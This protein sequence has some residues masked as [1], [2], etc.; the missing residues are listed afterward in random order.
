MHYRLFIFPFS[1]LT[2]RTKKGQL[3]DAN[4][5]RE[6]IHTNSDD[7]V[8]KKRSSI[9]KFSR[10]TIKSNLEVSDSISA[11]PSFPAKKRV[12]VPQCLPSETPTRTE[13]LE[14]RSDENTKEGFKNISSVPRENS[15][16]NERG[17]AVLSP[18]FWL[19]DDEGLEKLSQHTIGSQHLDIT[20]PDIP[21][22]SDIKDSD[23]DCPSKLSTE[24]SDQPSV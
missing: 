11:K 8:Q 22:F 24:V 21:T 14:I 4:C 17:E 15:A 18:F 3:D 5:G 1:F 6:D 19:R 12:Q 10:K 7:R 13:K 16:P 9:R 20:P 23:D 2:C